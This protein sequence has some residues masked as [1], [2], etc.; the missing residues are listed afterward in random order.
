MD[1]GIFLG[2]G[3][4]VADVAV[5]SVVCSEVSFSNVLSFDLTAIRLISRRSILH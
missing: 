1:D 2:P 5:L 3:G 4:D